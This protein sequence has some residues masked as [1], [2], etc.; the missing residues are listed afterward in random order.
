MITNLDE[1]A[2]M[3]KTFPLLKRILMKIDQVDIYD[4]IETYHD[5]LE[6]ALMLLEKSDNL[7]ALR[8][9]RIEFLEKAQSDAGWQREFDAAQ[10]PTNPYDEWRNEK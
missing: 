9:L 10:N 2:V 7:N 1:L 5:D 4:I 3:K 8:I 6:E